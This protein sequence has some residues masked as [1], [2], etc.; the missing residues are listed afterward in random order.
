[1][2]LLRL[3]L[4]IAAMVLAGCAGR[5][6]QRVAVAPSFAVDPVRSCEAVLYRAI[7]DDASALAC[8]DVLD[9]WQ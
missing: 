6:P 7:D 8:A 5:T 1:M 9:A 4:I 3:S 2:F